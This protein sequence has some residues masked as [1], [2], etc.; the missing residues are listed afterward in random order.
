MAGG[1][2]AANTNEYCVLHTEIELFATGRKIFKQRKLL[3]RYPLRPII[4]S[5]FL[6]WPGVKCHRFMKSIFMFRAIFTLRQ[7]SME[8]AER[9]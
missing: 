2:R 3:R 5:G 6:V 7:P 9:Q 4:S 1:I 8:H